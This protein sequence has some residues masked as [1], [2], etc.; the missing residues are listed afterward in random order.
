MFAS[1]LCTYDLSKVVVNIMLYDCCLCK[2]LSA[3]RVVLC[4]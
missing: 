2:D 1:T 3:D 4:V